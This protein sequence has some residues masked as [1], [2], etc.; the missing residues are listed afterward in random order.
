MKSYLSRLWTCVVAIATSWIDTMPHVVPL[1][2]LKIIE[3][4][5]ATLALA[6]AVVM[7]FTVFLAPL[8]LWHFERQQAIAKANDALREAMSDE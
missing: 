6:I 3:L 7:P 5:G 2:L 8:W 4:I 1:L